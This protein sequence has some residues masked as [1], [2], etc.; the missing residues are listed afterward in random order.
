MRARHRQTPETLSARRG[1]IFS[2]SL[3]SGVAFLF[4]AQGAVSSLLSL[5]T[6]QVNEVE[7]I[8]PAQMHPPQRYRLRPA[9]SIFR[10]DLEAVRQALQKE[11]PTVEIQ[12]VRKVFPNRLVALVRFRRKIAQVRIGKTYY[13]VS[14]DGVVTAGG[15]T[16]P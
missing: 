2:V 11:Q 6:F 14:E 16:A 10:L 12:E 7:V 9:A 4:A 3:L 8:W 13:P 1:R 15:G 5:R